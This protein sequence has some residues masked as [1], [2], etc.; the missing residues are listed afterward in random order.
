MRGRG[1][2]VVREPKGEFNRE[3]KVVDK[4]KKQREREEKGEKRITLLESPA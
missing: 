3:V 1:W 4:K 2:R